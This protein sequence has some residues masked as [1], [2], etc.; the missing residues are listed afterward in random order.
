MKRAIDLF[1]RPEKSSGETRSASGRC[2]RGTQ[3]ERD[4]NAMDHPIFNAI[5]LAAVGLAIDTLV[6]EL[7]RRGLL[8]GNE[9][10]AWPTVHL[11]TPD[12]AFDLHVPRVPREGGLL[13]IPSKVSGARKA[14]RV[15]AVVGETHLD[16][17]M[18]PSILATVE[19][20]HVESAAPP[21]EVP[22]SSSTMDKASP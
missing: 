21:T 12:D 20:R 3:R 11:V 17:E 6:R 22:T 13:Y 16:T 2:S 14:M 9:H 19:V 5:L 10:P 7:R 18:E 8:P 15:H 1:A 4:R